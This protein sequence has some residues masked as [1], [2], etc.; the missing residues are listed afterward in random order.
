MPRI[1]RK[2]WND[3]EGGVISVEL[4]LIIGVLVF[5]LIPGLVA[6]RNSGI[7]ALTTLG[8]LVNVLIPSFTFSGFS[9]VSGSSTIVQVNGVAFNPTFTPLTG[10]Q[11]PPV[12]LSSLEVPPAP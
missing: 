6:L 4:V 5:G 3:E 7:S 1:L 2:I 9:I 12:V 8:N 11:L 10:S